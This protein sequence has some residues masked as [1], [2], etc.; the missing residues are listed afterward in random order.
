M[1]L[2]AHSSNF[3]KIVY[4][5]QT[6]PPK[7]QGIFKFI[8][9]PETGERCFYHKDSLLG[10]DGLKHGESYTVYPINLPK[11]IFG[12]EFSNWH[13]WGVKFLFEE[14]IVEHT[15]EQLS[16]IS[17]PIIDFTS[18]DWISYLNEYDL[19]YP[20]LMAYDDNYLEVMPI[21]GPGICPKISSFQNML[22]IT[23][24]GLNLLSSI[25]FVNTNHLSQY[26]NGTELFV[27]PML[28]YVDDKHGLYPQLKG[29]LVDFNIFLNKSEKEYL[30]EI[31][32]TPSDRNPLDF[33]A[34]ISTIPKFS[35]KLYCLY[36]VG[37]DLNW[38]W[39]T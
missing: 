16:F 14:E 20:I 19:K 28:G 6:M 9:N 32:S 13:T 7:E 21:T 27:Y 35:N 18:E 8:R 29:E 37:Q 38:N 17:K 5:N 33:S 15:A 3:D 1:E 24:D 23:D 36:F 30:E 10:T 31:I 4:D 39:C 34:Q 11:P 12:E 22:K 2:H 26:P 25:S